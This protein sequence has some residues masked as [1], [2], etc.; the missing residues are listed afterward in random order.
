M[1]PPTP[2]TLGQLFLRHAGQFL[3][4]LRLLSTTTLQFVAALI[5]L[6]A[7]TRSD[8]GADVLSALGAG[9]FSNPSSHTY[10]D[11]HRRA[12]WFIV[13]NIAAGI[14]IWW[15]A[16]MTLEFKLIPLPLPWRFWKCVRRHVRIWW[17]R[18]L[19]AGAVLGI[20]VAFL[21]DARDYGFKQPAKNP[22]PAPI[23][24]GAA[25]PGTTPAPDKTSEP[26]PT[27]PHTIIPATV[28]KY[29]VGLTTLGYIHCAIAPLLLFA[30]FSRRWWLRKKKSPEP[31]PRYRNVTDVVDA[32]S[33]GFLFHRKSLVVCSLAVL[34]SLWISPIP[35]GHHSWHRAR[36]FPSRPS[37]GSLGAHSC[38][39]GQA[40]TGLPV[41]VLLILWAAWCS[42]KMDNHDIRL[43][44]DVDGQPGLV[45][46]TNEKDNQPGRWSRQ[47]RSNFSSRRLTK[48]SSTRSRE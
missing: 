17:P 16:R 37:V 25:V 48:P 38:W 13:I 44:H 7:Y 26:L 22:G 34:L 32:I 11:D 20:G 12:V 1:T 6:V 3:A 2:L 35:W 21:I 43:S 41:I 30:F 14:V 29:R 15:S 42:Y 45:R 40:R 4:I 19:G 9:L 5:P 27:K 23:Q 8:Q 39:N 10:T 33:G 31:G 18:L 36:S 46:L 28:Q 24:A 47:C